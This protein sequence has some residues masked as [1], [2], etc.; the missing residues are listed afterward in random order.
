MRK[1]IIAALILICAIAHADPYKAI[2][3]FPPGGGADIA[4]RHFQKYADSR[5]INIIANYKSGA[6]GLIGMGEVASADD[7]TIGFGTVATVAV[8]QN[9]NPNYQF[10]YVSM[11]RTSIFALVTGSANSLQSLSEVQNELSKVDTKKSFGYGAP[12]Q[13]IL[14]EELF[15]FTDLKNGRRPPTLVAY[16][17]GAPLMT[18]VM[19]GHVDVAILPLILAKP[20]IDAGK[21]RLLAL[22]NRKPLHDSEFVPILNK[23]YPLWQDA[24]GYCI[25]LPKDARQENLVF[26]NKLVKE[27]LED[28][29]TR[30][31]FVIDFSESVDIGP[32]HMKVIV[33]S[34][35]KNII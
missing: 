17:G 19:G 12:A 18:D 7:S 31:D 21:L 23:V 10:E 25:V 29:L 6:D 8:Y 11:I 15:K 24:D 4:F 1:I 33:D 30:K 20:M 13:K 26:W 22:S 27:Y 35:A 9:K 2:I 28:P 3:P 16:K 5:G 14:M 32:K 34:V